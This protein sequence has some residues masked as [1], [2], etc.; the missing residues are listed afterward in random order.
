MGNPIIIRGF[1]GGGW[2]CPDYWL[3]VQIESVD[4]FLTWYVMRVEHSFC[5]PMRVSGPPVQ[6][7]GTEGGRMYRLLVIEAN[8]VLSKKCKGDTD[9]F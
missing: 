5:S 4:K 3:P 7:Q 1:P 6:A 2:G 9:K 8:W